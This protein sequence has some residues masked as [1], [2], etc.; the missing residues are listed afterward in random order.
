MDSCVGAVD[1]LSLM[2]CLVALEVVLTHVNI[3]SM[4]NL[5]YFLNI[6]LRLLLW[7]LLALYDFKVHTMLQQVRK[8]RK[9][10]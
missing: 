1:C 8:E 4:D 6:K 3:Y 5:N 9:S 10:N 2:W 7:P